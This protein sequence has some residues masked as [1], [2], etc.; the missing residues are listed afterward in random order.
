MPATRAI[1]R[2][3]DPRSP[4]IPD[5]GS[6][7][8]FRITGNLSDEHTDAQPIVTLWRLAWND[9]RLACTVY[10]DGE[11]LQLRLESA[12]AVILAEPFDLQPRMFARTQSLRESLRRRG[13][14][15]TPTVD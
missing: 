5:P 15:E 11:G 6:R 12:T 4:L 2:D 14:Q 8:P 9:D 7:I 13:W 3:P 1:A 10:R